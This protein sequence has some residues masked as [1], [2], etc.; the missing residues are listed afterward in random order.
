MGPPSS[1]LTSLRSIDMYRKVPY[2]LST[3][4]RYSR[5]LSLILA[6]SLL[7][8][9]LVEVRRHLK[10]DVWTDVYMDGG[11][12][13]ELTKRNMWVG[14]SKGNKKYGDGRGQRRG[15]RRDA[16]I[17]MEFNVTVMRVTCE[18][19]VVQLWDGMGKNEMD[20]KTNVE[21]WALDENGNRKTYKGRN[22]NPPNVMHDHDE[23]GGNNVHGDAEDVAG[24]GGSARKID[25]RNFEG[26]VVKSNYLFVMFTKEKGCE[27]CENIRPTWGTLAS[28]VKNSGGKVS[29]ATLYCD[30]SVKNEDLC[31]SNAVPAFP[32]LRM[33][34]RGTKWKGDYKGDR[35]L[36]GIM[37]YLES[38]VSKT[39]G[40]SLGGGAIEGASGGQ[41]EKSAISNQG[42]GW[43]ENDY[44]GCLINGYAWVN[45][46]PGRLTILPS[47][48]YQTVDVSYLNVSHV[49]HNFGF[50]VHVSRRDRERLKG[51]PN[52]YKIDNAVNGRAYI[53]RKKG[54]VH[55]HSISV[56]PTRYVAGGGRSKGSYRPFVKLQGSFFRAAIDAL[57]R[58]ATLGWS[59]SGGGPGAGNI[60]YNR[61]AGTSYAVTSQ[62]IPKIT[63]AYDVSPMVVAF[64]DERGKTWDAVVR[65]MAVIGGVVKIFQ[66]FEQMVG[67]G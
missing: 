51:V 66:I 24:G 37:T 16:M 49:V 18:M 26:E 56:V 40:G 63:F 54:E 2:D 55:H 42:R 34:H 10:P 32:T 6:L 25:Y 36:S 47:S 7:A 33:Y 14:N 8:F 65:G 28:R 5:T 1:F 23:K 35:T 31:K 11:A 3:S 22:P 15:G 45:K 50:G 38:A 21:K 53:A 13:G 46:I 12:I 48:S 9:V 60:D 20:L 62:S 41:L 52:E 39:G 17:M 29:V 67:G 61:L 43:S 58:A 19:A 59:S 30:E 44:P 57:W 4:S 27:W 64:G